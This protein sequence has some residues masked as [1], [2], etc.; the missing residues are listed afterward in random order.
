MAVGLGRE[1]GFGHTCVSDDWVVLE[2]EPVGLFFAGEYTV[3][4]RY[5]LLVPD[6]VISVAIFSTDVVRLLLSL[7]V[8][9]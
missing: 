4:S 5:A 8:R 3:D 2:L 9:E 6:S 7:L 1:G